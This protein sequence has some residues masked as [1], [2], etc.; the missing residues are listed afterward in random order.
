MRKIGASAAAVVMAQTALMMPNAIAETAPN[1]DMETAI[2]ME[3]EAQEIDYNTP[4]FAQGYEAAAAM[5]ANPSQGRTAFR[6][7]NGCSFSPD[8]VGK[9]NFRPAC[10]THDTCYSRNSRTNRLDCDNRFL[11]NLRR[12]CDTTRASDF[13]KR[14]CRSL[15]GGYY[16]AVRNFGHRFYQGRGLNN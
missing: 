3:L 12:V 8:R 5:M 7:P 11:S 9:F 13:E 10:D 4:E 6:S 14:S 16:K 1:A 2:I 15:A